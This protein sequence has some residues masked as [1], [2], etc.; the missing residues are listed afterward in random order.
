MGCHSNKCNTTC[1]CFMQD[2]D[3][4]VQKKSYKVVAYLCESRTEF[5]EANLQVGLHLH[6]ARCTRVSACRPFWVSCVCHHRQRQAQNGLMSS[7]P[8]VHFVCKG[9]RTLQYET[10]ALNRSPVPQ[11][12]AGSAGCA[13][14]QRE[15]RLIGRAALSAALREGRRAAAGHPPRPAQQQAGKRWHSGT[16]AAAAAAA[17]D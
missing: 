15:G 11:F 12:S 13:A 8:G 1:C 14:D 4:G 6:M 10:H 3:S 5:L 17:G 7:K 16:A 2:K 9:G